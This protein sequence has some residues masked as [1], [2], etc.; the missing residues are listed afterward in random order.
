VNVL[1]RAAKLQAEGTPFVL[2]TVTWRR[3]PSSGKGGSKAIIRTDATIEG[4]IGGACARDSVVRFALEALRSGES[5]LLVLGDSDTR[6]EVEVISMACA[7]EGAMEV[8]VEPVLPQPQA[9]IVGSSPM[10]DTLR[11]LVAVVGWSVSSTEDP[12]VAADSGP[13]SFVVVAS[14]GHYDEPAVEAALRSEATYIGLVASE[15]RASAVKA[16]LRESGASDEDVARIR[17]PAGMDLGSTEHHEIAVAILAELVA[18]KA[19]GAGMQVV[20]VELPQQAIDPVCEMV[21]DV[22]RARFVTEHKGVAHYFCAAG[23]QR[24]FE[25]SPALFLGGSN[26]S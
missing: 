19:A 13:R 10:V 26:D 11:R 15:K 9:L 4:W 24:A 21:V 8:Y 7:S 6:S 2:A 22:A 17:A 12:V 5:R 25:S 1:A 20:E 14:Q 23:C 18:F 16:W 3:G